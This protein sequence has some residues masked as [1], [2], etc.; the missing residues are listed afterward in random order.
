MNMF[1]QYRSF[2]PQVIYYT[3]ADFQQ[4]REQIPDYLESQENLYECGGEE[5]V[6]PEDLIAYY[7]GLEK[8]AKKIREKAPIV[9]WPEASNKM[10]SQIGKYTFDI[11]L[12]KIAQISRIAEV[13]PKLNAILRTLGGPKDEWFMQVVQYAETNYSLLREDQFNAFKRVGWN[14]EDQFLNIPAKRLATGLEWKRPFDALDTELSQGNFSVLE[15]YLDQTHDRLIRGQGWFGVGEWGVASRNYLNALALAIATNNIDA[16]EVITRFLV[17]TY[18]ASRNY[19]SAI[20]LVNDFL[21]SQAYRKTNL[22]YPTREMLESIAIGLAMEHMGIECKE[23]LGKIPRL[24][25]TT[26]DTDV[27]K[28]RISEELI[29]VYGYKENKQALFELN[30]AIKLVG[31]LLPNCNRPS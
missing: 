17:D 19:R 22:N 6:Q 12:I 5:R 18:V 31:Q 21:S 15:G 8:D 10:L 11:C 4:L 28:W 24:C 25:E 14:W 3:A 27:Y 1:E 7:D 23:W 29:D 16:V 20:N 30:L 2:Y 9:T 26:S 13:Q